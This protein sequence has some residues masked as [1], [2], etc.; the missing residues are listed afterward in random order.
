M[1][2]MLMTSIRVTVELRDMKS[3][4]VASTM[5]TTKGLVVIHVAVV[6]LYSIC[7]CCL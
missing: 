6:N 3:F 4:I 7:S 2:I 5:L 1:L